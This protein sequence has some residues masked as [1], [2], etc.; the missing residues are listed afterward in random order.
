MFIVKVFESK[1]FSLKTQLILSVNVQ[2][3]H[4]QNSI[5]TDNSP[6][7]RVLY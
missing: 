4:P 2:N 6:V 7:V 5:M 1:R 3:L